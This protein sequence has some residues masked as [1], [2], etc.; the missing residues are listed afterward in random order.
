MAAFETLLASGDSRQKRSAPICFHSGE[1]LTYARLKKAFTVRLS[2]A[3]PLERALSVPPEAVRSIR[4]RAQCQ[5]ITLSLRLG[6]RLDE[7]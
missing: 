4:T 5:L 1:R 3:Q 7:R 6:R 2:A